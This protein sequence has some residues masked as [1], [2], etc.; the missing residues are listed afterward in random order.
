MQKLIITQG[1]SGSGKSTWAKA[2]VAKD[3]ENWVRS[4]RDD[5]RAQMFGNPTYDQIQEKAVRV[6]QEGMVRA[7]LAAGKSVVVD[8]TNIDVLDIDCWQNLAHF[9]GVDFEI[10]PFNISV[11]GAKANISK[12]AAAGGLF[13]PDHIVETQQSALAKLTQDHPWVS[14]LSSTTE[15]Y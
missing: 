3:A 6:A 1:I 5:L 9:M 2:L 14:S 13:V 10:R 8:N 11:E 4:S 7:L 12:R 15:T